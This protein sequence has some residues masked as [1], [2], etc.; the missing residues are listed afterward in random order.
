MIILNPNLKH[1]I[2]IPT[3]TIEIGS[4]L[5]INTRTC[6]LEIGKYFK[7]SGDSSSNFKR[8][9]GSFKE[10]DKGEITIN[11]KD[12]LLKK[13]NWGDTIKKSKIGN[14]I[15]HKEDPEKVLVMKSFTIRSMIDQRILSSDS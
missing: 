9:I 7:C 2:K 5:I 3:M 1:N 14:T 6:I 4:K 12:R 8:S 11:I 13:K 15:I 10:K